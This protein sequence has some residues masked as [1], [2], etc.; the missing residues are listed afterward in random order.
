MKQIINEETCKNILWRVN[1]AIMEGDDLPFKIFKGT[2]LN[3]YLIVNNG[4]VGFK[5]RKHYKYIII[6][7]QYVNEWGGKYLLIQTDNEKVYNKYLK[8]FEN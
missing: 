6:L 3:N 7:E 2:L 1:D 5:N 8:Q 4:I